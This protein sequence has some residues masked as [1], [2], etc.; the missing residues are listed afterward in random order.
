MKERLSAPVW[1]PERPCNLFLHVPV[2]AAK[3]RQA[4]LYA[5]PLGAPGHWC[6]RAFNRDGDGSLEERHTSSSFPAVDGPAKESKPDSGMSP[7]LNTRHNTGAQTSY[8]AGPS[9]SRVLSGR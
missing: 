5:V 6:V 9:P 8:L 1:F 7:R 4:G 2:E 3:S